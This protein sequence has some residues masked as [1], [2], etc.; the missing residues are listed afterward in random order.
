[1]YQDARELF[2]AR[3][4]E[5]AR[6]IL[7]RII[8][9]NAVDSIKTRADILISYMD[10]P[11]FDTLKDKIAYRDVM[12]DP[13]L[14]RDCY[15]AWKGMATNLQVDQNSTAFEFLVGYDT[16]HTLEGIVPVSFNFSV[17][18]NL[19][20]PL[21]ILGKI[22]PSEDGSDITIEGTAVHQSGILGGK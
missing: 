17:A 11:G 2:N 22:V 4:D 16:R 21:E 6:V 3:H 15:V 14:Y 8:E 19:E 7:N 13:L 18:V 5:Q 12:K 20:K 9:S 1:M 10:V